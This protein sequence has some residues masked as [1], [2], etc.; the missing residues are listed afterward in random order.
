VVGRVERGDAGLGEKRVEAAQLGEGDDA[1]R[2][3]VDRRRMRRVAPR[4]Q[5]DLMVLFGIAREEGDVHAADQ[6]AVGD[7]EAEHAGVELDHRR[8]VDDED[9]HVRER[10]LRSFVHRWPFRAPH[11][12]PAVNFDARALN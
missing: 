7:A 5:D 3:L 6:G 11:A 12:T 1:K 9:P 2:D 4:H 8:H 10:H